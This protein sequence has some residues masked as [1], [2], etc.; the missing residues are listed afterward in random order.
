MKRASF[1]HVA[2]A[3]ALLLLI[4]VPS[5]PAQE[6]TAR[7]VADEVATLAKGRTHAQQRAL[8][9][10]GAQTDPE[11]DKVLLTQFARYRTGQLPL[12]L[13]L[14][15]FEAAAK[16]DNPT[17]KAML[18]EREHEVEKSTDPL[19]RFRE[20][21]EG[22]DADAGRIILTRKPEAGCVRCHSVVGQG[23]QIGPDLTWLRHSTDR[24]RVLES[25]ILP[26]STIAMGYQSALLKLKNG[27]EISGVVSFES[28]DDLTLVSVVDGKKRTLKTAEIVERTPLPSPMPPHFGAVLSKRE[29]RDLIE[30]LAVGD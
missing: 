30:F 3:V 25:L 24:I 20:C 14:D 16:R 7:T 1:L 2:S 26:N 18:A 27:E 12:A 23:G 6:Q 10:L 13:W 5:A 28:P 21:L 11:A 17:L 29:I 15:L 19:M 8:A 4:C 22:G 9:R